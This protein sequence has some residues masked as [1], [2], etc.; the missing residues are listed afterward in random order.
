LVNLRSFGRHA[1][2]AFTRG[3]SLDSRSEDIM[4]DYQANGSRYAKE[5]G[6][7]GATTATKT[8]LGQATGGPLNDKRLV[9]RGSDQERD[10]GSSNR[11]VGRRSR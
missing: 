4:R 5:R 7:E 10:G 3:L 8:P 1:V 2:T 11:S 6:H 9:W